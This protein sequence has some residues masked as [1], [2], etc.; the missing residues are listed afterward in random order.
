L[1]RLRLLIDED[2]SKGPQL[3]VALR[4]RGFD[5]VAVQEVGRRGNAQ[6]YPFSAGI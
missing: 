6:H 1:A 5:A 3:A 2:A 4:R